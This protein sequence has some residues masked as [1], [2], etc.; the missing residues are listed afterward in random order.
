[1]SGLSAPAHLLPTIVQVCAN[2]AAEGG[3]G[4]RGTGRG[5]AGGGK[6]AA[7]RHAAEAAGGPARPDPSQRLLRLALSLGA[8][9][10]ALDGQ[11]RA[12]LA[13]ACAKNALELIK[14]LVSQRAW[15]DRTAGD[16]IGNPSVVS[17]S[18][19]VHQL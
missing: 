7:L 3:R 19:S 4:E 10:A 6:G 15:T 16:L 12:P 2:D 13:L 1:M 14:C 17:Q 9:A 5:T 18:M 11:G 8:D